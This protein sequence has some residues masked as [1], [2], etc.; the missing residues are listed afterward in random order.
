MS[1]AS[2]RIR[3]HANT[4][5]RDR[6][7][8]NS[9][10]EWFPKRPRSHPPH[11]QPTMNNATYNSQLIRSSCTVHSKAALNRTPPRLSSFVE[12]VRVVFVVLGNLSAS[13]GAYHI[14]VA[15]L[16]YAKKIRRPSAGSGQ[17][18]RMYAAKSPPCSAFLLCCD[19]ET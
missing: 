19:S 17:C 7:Q 1:Y 10:T 2:H 5:E 4:K 13:F 6:S 14:V 16:S 9:S 18:S 11:T 8:T 15:P 12:S 3:K